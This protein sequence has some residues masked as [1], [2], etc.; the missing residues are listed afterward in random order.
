ML[1][2][3]TAL[4]DATAQAAEAASCAWAKAV[5]HPSRPKPCNAPGPR[6]ADRAA[7]RSLDPPA[8]QRLSCS[9][10]NQNRETRNMA[11]KSPKIVEVALG[12]EINSYV[13]A[14]L[15]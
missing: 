1:M 11:W 8:R 3:D 9:D 12:G 15:K 14:R 6:M 7:T 10:R 13:C 4:D 2:A 5:V